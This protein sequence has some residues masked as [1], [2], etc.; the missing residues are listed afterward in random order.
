VAVQVWPGQPYPLG[1]TYDGAGT[2]FALFSEVAE[3]VELC[4]FDDA[5]VETRYRLPEVTAFVWHGY[6]PN[7]G[8]GQRY[9]FRVHGPFD[10]ASGLWCNPAKLL[11]D[12]YAKAVDS[13][14]DWDEA[15]FAHLFADPDARND[16]DSAPH[17]PKSVVVSP[18]F[19][20]AND[21]QPRTP[22]HETV[23]YEVHVKGFTQR[24]RRIPPELRG[25]SSSRSTSSCRT[26]TC[27]TGAC[28][29]TGAT[30][31]SASWRPTTSTR[32]PAPTASRCRSSSRW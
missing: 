6:V 32:P 22:W 23:V 25:S 1:A 20:W 27:S 19:D 16:A 18:Y 26:T 5:G 8:P 9:G 12:P 28:A 15:C 3:R 21:R 11:L 13:Q 10:P 2:N 4:L 17:V 31:R 14:V 24:H 7:L 30:T 29:T